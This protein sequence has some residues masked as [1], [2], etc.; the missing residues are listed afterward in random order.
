MDGSLFHWSPLESLQARNEHGKVEDQKRAIVYDGWVFNQLISTMLFSENISTVGMIWFALV[1]EEAQTGAFGQILGSCSRQFV[2]PLFPRLSLSVLAPLLFSSSLVSCVQL[3][4]QTQLRWWIC[5]CSV[6]V[7]LTSWCIST[8]LNSLS[9]SLC[10]PQVFFS[11]RLFVSV[12]LP[13]PLSL[14]LF[15]SLL[16]S[17]TQWLGIVWPPASV[18]EQTEHTDPPP[19]TT[20]NRNWAPRF[21]HWFSLGAFLK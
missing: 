14:I 17:H 4:L 2:F 13:P 20:T 5:G 9:I 7:C 15:L 6:S 10:P 3:C 21:A 1:A 19:T 18:M 8:G 12:S 16:L 11:L